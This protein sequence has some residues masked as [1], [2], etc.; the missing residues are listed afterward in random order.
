MSDTGFVLCGTGAD[1]ASVGT[2]AWVNPGNITADDGTLATAG[3]S[4]VNPN[5]HYLKGTNF[6][7]SVPSGATI[8]GIQ[9]RWKLAN[10][11]ANSSVDQAILTVDSSGVI[12]GSNLGTNTVPGGSTTLTN[13]DFG[14]ATELW[15]RSWT[16]ADVNNANF[17]CVFQ[18]HRTAGGSGTNTRADALWVKV[19]YTE[20]A[21]TNPYY[22]AEHIARAA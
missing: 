13:Y 11:A 19:F 21:A 2:V 22:Y 6:G 15:G 7:L 12:G 17:G 18:A 4:G 10:V 20:A 3:V 1:D 16:A 5:S 14:G 8:D 9:F